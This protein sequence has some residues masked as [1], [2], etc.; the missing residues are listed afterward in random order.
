MIHPDVI[1]GIRGITQKALKAGLFDFN[2][3]ASLARI[4][5]ALDVEERL[6]KEEQK[7]LQTEREERE[8]NSPVEAPA[9][10]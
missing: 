1:N 8:K 5:G 6:W 4:A 9:A 7:R 3:L 2:E 10:E